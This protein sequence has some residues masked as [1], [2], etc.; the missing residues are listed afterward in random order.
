MP[1]STLPLNAFRAAG[2]EPEPAEA[3]PDQGPARAQE[4]KR[5]DN[6]RPRPSYDI[7]RSDGERRGGAH[8]P[9]RQGDKRPLLE[10]GDDDAVY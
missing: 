1:L 9:S 8:K 4:G 7:R 2:E 10:D 5:A 6:P 3:L